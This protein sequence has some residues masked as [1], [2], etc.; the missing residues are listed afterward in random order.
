MSILSAYSSNTLSSRPPPSLRLRSWHGVRLPA[1]P[2]RWVFCRHFCTCRFSWR[3]DALPLAFQNQSSFRLGHS[4]DNMEL[5]LLESIAFSRRAVADKFKFFLVEYDCDSLFFQGSDDGKQ[6]LEVPGQPV[7]GVDMEHVA[8][9]NVVQAGLQR[10]SICV[11]SGSVFLKNFIQVNAVQ[12]S[13]G[14]LV[15]RGNTDVAN[16]FTWHGG[17]HWIFVKK[18][19][20]SIYGKCPTIGIKAF[21]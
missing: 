20:L 16:I 14:V 21:V 9:P 3:Y 10:R 18:F 6:V 19:S 12:L 2:T 1:H 13:G 4:R 8:I 15:M 11:L 17:P 7:D 5:K